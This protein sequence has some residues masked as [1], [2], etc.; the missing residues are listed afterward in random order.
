MGYGAVASDPKDANKLVATTCAQWYSQA[1]TADA[2]ERNAIA[3]GDRFF[4]SEDGGETWTEIT[5][6][7][8]AYWD[9][10][11]LANYLQDGGH[12]WIRDK[13]IHWSGCIALD[14]RNS[15]QFW[16]VSGNG[17]S[18][19]K[20]HG[21]SAPTST[22]HRTASRKSYLWTS[23]ADRARIRFPSSATMTV[24]ITTQT[25]LQPS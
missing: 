2:W 12:S 17:V 16:V 13:A 9:G 20:T 21:Q 23:S 22:L 8:T 14:P 5:P 25:A 11:L 18:P 6:G 24:S 4:K 7:N 1:W 19:V 15:D 10:P 3:W